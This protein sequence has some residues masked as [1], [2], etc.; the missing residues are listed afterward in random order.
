MSVPT[1]AKLLESE[2]IDKS[3]HIDWVCHG[4][5]QFQAFSNDDRVPLKRSDTASSFGAR[6]YSESD[7]LLFHKLSNDRFG[8]DSVETRTETERDENSA[9]NGPNNAF[10]EH[11]VRSHCTNR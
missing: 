4:I 7:R 11:R 2:A 8:I 10:Y 1:N 5:L 9:R 3:A 6:A